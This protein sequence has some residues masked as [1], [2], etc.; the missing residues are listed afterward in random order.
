MRYTSRP[1]A[2]SAESRT[3]RNSTSV[4]PDGTPITI[5]SDGENQLRLL[6]DI[7]MRPRIICSH[8]VKSAIT[9]SRRGRTARILSGVRS[10]IILAS[11]PTAIILSVRLSRATTDGSSTTILLSLMMMV[12]A[13]PKSIA[14]SFTKEKSPIAVSLLLFL[15][16]VAASPSG[17][18]S[19]LIEN[20]TRI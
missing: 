9:P 15:F 2:C 12:L 5:R 14:T 4:E 3:A 20:R 19:G 13:V 7:L 8:A 6:C 16:V 17:L 11:V 1:S 10:Y 18:P